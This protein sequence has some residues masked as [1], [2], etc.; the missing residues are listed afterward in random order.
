MSALAK[1]VEFIELSMVGGTGTTTSGLLTKG[2]NIENCVPFVS[3]YCAN[4]DFS[5]QFI[6]TWFTDTDVPYVHIER[7]AASSSAL[8]AKL[9]VVEFDPNKVKVYQGD[10]PTSYTDGSDVSLVVTTSGSFDQG[11]TAMV[12]YYK[13]G[14]MNNVNRVNDGML[15]GKVNSDGTTISFMKQ[16][17]GSAFT[18][19]YYLFESIDNDF[20]VQHQTGTYTG[21]TSYE[22]GVYDWHNTFIL[23]SYCTAVDTDNIYYQTSRA[24][25]WGNSRVAMNRDSASYTCYYNIQTVEFSND[26][27]AS[28]V[29][30]CPKITSYHSMDSSSVERTLYFAEH[31]IQSSDTLSMTVAQTISRN[32]SNNSTRGACAIAVWLDEDQ[33]KYYIKRAE[34]GSNGYPTY[35]LV[36]WN[37]QYPQYV[38]TGNNPVPIASGTSFVKSVENIDTNIGEHVSVSH[39]SKGQDVD[40]CIVFKSGYCNQTS[41]YNQQYRHEALTYFRGNELY[42]ERGNEGWEHYTQASVV[43]FWPDQV[44]VQQGAFCIG[45]NETATTV[46]LEHEIDTSK[47]FMVFGHFFGGGEDA[48]GYH[49]CRGYV[50]SS[51]TLY[52]DRGT[53][54]TYPIMGTWYIAEDIAGNNWVVKHF[55]SEFSTTRAEQPSSAHNFNM[56]NTVNLI[57]SKID[58]TSA[59][60]Y[61]ACWRNYYHS[62]ISPAKVERM[63]ASYNSQVNM[64][65]IRFLDD[66]KIRVHYMPGEL[67]GTEASKTLDVYTS[68]SGLGVTAVFSNLH[69]VAHTELGSSSYNSLGFWATR[70]DE[71]TNK[72]TISRPSYGYS[73]NTRASIYTVCWEGYVPEGLDETINNESNYFVKSIDVFNYSGVTR[74]LGWHP[75]KG[76]DLRNCIISPMYSIGED[77]GSAEIEKFFWCPTVFADM[78]YIFFETFWTADDNGGTDMSIYLIEFDPAQVKVQY[79]VDLIW[80][81]SYTKTVT[82]EEVDSSKAFVMVYTIPNENVGTAFGSCTLA[83]KID[84]STQLHFE[85]G[86]A[87]GDV[88]FSWFVVECLQEQWSV[89]HGEINN[90]NVTAYVYDCPNVPEHNTISYMSYAHDQTSLYPAYCFFRCYPDH[91]QRGIYQIQANRQSTSSEVERMNFAVIT[92]NDNLGVYTD[93]VHCY[94]GGT[95]NTTTVDLGRSY[96]INRTVL[97]PGQPWPVGRTNTTSTSEGPQRAFAKF[98][99]QDSNTLVVTR[100]PDAYS[101]ET[102]QHVYLIEF[103]IPSHKVSGVVRE[104]GSF[105]SRKLHLHDTTTGDLLGETT[106]SGVDG[107]YIFYTTCS[108]S[109]YVVCFDD[110][111]GVVYNGL[112]ETDV[113]PIPIENS[114]PIKEGW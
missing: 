67:L 93:H 58:S 105:V 35:Y 95:T 49:S 6:D 70:Y 91:D 4:D 7:F 22:T 1:S 89:N 107:T 77:S 73:V 25:L 103:P 86:Y 43:E 114:W 110:P 82:I 40:N 78:G 18:G 76:Q 96:D 109:T 51:T 83:A 42:F 29:R 98:A 24:Y 92:F 59:Y 10:M 37:G 113:M 26:A 13:V 99:F 75:S 74:C 45:M 56:F 69:G 31:Y 14:S 57:S 97:W 44:R 2:Q 47:T 30:Y 108:G 112:I 20:T 15:R 111:D 65:S 85:R 94:L 23:H 53:S 87:T 17:S 21:D 16:T 12:F 62:T 33:T 68:F 28:G 50:S 100:S 5:G 64:Q 102:W 104:K 88:K 19:H 9:Y 41:S 39:L 11:S 52:F 32:S 55:N 36:D 71:T 54:F 106:S 48:W 90:S 61:H 79:G 80:G 8:Y 101:V 34:S 72:V 46:T 3:W 66:S 81:G 63:A 27:T 38:D 84:T 60:G